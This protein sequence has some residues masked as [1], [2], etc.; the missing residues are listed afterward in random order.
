[1]ELGLPLVTAVAVTNDCPPEARPPAESTMLNVSFTEQ[2]TPP[3]SVG[4]PYKTIFCAAAVPPPPAPLLGV[5]ENVGRAPASVAEFQFDDVAPC[6][7]T[8]IEETCPG[9]EKEAD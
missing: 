7:E 3:V 2:P 1:M 8:V 5:N 4:A 6:V 9:L